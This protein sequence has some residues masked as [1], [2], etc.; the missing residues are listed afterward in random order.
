MAQVTLAHCE[1]PHKLFKQFVFLLSGKPQR[2]GSAY[3]FF[4][5]S[6]PTRQKAAADSIAES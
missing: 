3:L 4:L 2:E 5:H 6:F 1:T